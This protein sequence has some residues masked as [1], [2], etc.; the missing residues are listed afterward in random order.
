MFR[1]PRGTVATALVAIGCAAE[2][3][4]A[5][6]AMPTLQTDRPCY[7]PGESI[8][9]TG[10][11]YTPN[12]EVDFF[13]SLMGKNGSKLLAGNPTDADGSGNI[14]ATYEAPELASS[15]D[16]S[17]GLVATAND[18][19]RQ[20]PGSTAPPEDQFGAAEA[21]LSTFDVFVPPWDDHK[22]DPR[23][24]VRVKAFGYEPATRLWA[25]Y[26]R[27]GHLVKTVFIGKLR[28]PCGNLTKRIREFPFRPVPAG[29]Y[30]VYF[31][32]SKRLDKRQG[33]PYRRV[34]VSARKAVR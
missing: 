30:A 19:A 31:Q 14:R 5:S 10:G 33:T 32:G 20:A 26:V 18:Q 13:F 4:G 3:G 17:E 7:T 24:K 28:G 15:D 8:T 34:R 21:T 12:G 1:L 16:T 29:T 23:R 11:G 27:N 9:Y 6:A 25:H 2:A 22:V